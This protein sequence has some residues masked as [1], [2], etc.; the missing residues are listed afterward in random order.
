MVWKRTIPLK[1]VEDEIKLRIMKHLVYYPFDLRD[2]D[3]PELEKYASIL[4][5]SIIG[6]LETGGIHDVM[7]DLGLLKK[8]K[9]EGL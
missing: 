1:S 7:K 3:P 8:L 9:Q 5:R 2:V 4:A 6:Y